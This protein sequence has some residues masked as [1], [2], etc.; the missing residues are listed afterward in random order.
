MKRRSQAERSATTREK[1]IQ[2]VIDCIVEEGIQNTTASRIAKRSGMTWGAIVHQ[3]GDKDSV[4][5]A[6]VEHNLERFALGMLETPQS[7]SKPLTE[8]V[9]VLI[10]M[11]WEHINQPCSHAFTE[12]VLYGR[13]HPNGK[14]TTTQEEL[15]LNLTKKVL[16]SFFGYLDIDAKT[17]E[18]ARNISSATLLGMS[19]QG[20][21]SPSRKPRFKKEI[22]AL[23]I[24]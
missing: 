18:T 14:I 20:I 2:T 16:R 10:D 6:V 13:S 3:F 24:L 8:R 22:T 9:S 17:L 4:F 1:V 19:I 12:L 15:T 21:I 5:L 23:K 11:S 7:Q